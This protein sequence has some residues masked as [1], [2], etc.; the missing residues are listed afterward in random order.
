MHIIA[1]VFVLYLCIIYEYLL[2]SLRISYI[3][4]SEKLPDD[5]PNKPKGF[6]DKLGA[7]ISASLEVRDI[8]CVLCIS[9]LVFFIF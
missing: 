8:F 1:H 6:F 5:N 4:C 2:M 3:I 9:Y 7:K